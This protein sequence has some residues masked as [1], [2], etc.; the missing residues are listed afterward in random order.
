MKNIFKISI[1]LLACSMMNNLSAQ[2]NACDNMNRKG[3]GLPTV[4][5]PPNG[6]TIPNPPTVGPPTL[7]PP[8]EKEKIVFWIHGFGGNNTSWEKASAISTDW[9]HHTTSTPSNPVFINDLIG[10]P[11]RKIISDN[12]GYSSGLELPDYGETMDND[13]WNKS[14]SVNQED[15]ES[16][17]N[18]CI[19]H[20]FGG[21]VTRRA[22]IHGRAND[23]FRAGGIATFG[24]PHHGAVLANNLLEVDNSTS[25]KYPFETSE[26][27]AT[28]KLDNF[29]EEAAYSLKAGP[30]KEALESNFWL[31]LF[32]GTITN[33]VNK[34]V[35]G[36]IDFAPTLVGDLFSPTALNLQVGNEQVEFLQNNPNLTTNVTFYGVEERD[37]TLWRLFYWGKNDPNNPALSLRS[38]QAEGYFEASED[39]LAI[40]S[41]NKNLAKYEA[42]YNFWKLH[43]QMLNRAALRELLS[44]PFNPIKWAQLKHAENE[45]KI[46][47]NAW[48]KGMHWWINSSFYWDLMTGA[49]TFEYTSGTQCICDGFSGIPEQVDCNDINNGN[50]TNCREENG[51]IQIAMLYR[52]N[53]GAVLQESA[54]DFPGSRKNAIMDG[55]NHFQMRNDENT[56]GA[57]LALFDAKDSAYLFFKTKKK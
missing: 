33:I 13:I 12:P 16:K 50:Y 11:A 7:P 1:L 43:H 26:L 14:I 42:K 47:R 40:Q 30:I 51:N 46:I 52:P 6:G 20:S 57:L 21:L 31:D 34:I 22:E 44:I 36:I 2:N 27:K 9:I 38:V 49:V 3:L 15:W 32:D 35:D 29:L 4:E 54:I 53:D 19:P 39:R 56:K 37:L 41:F 48:E 10:F 25:I 23:G 18:F 24:T 28:E 17:F 8:H 55:S 45:A 5:V